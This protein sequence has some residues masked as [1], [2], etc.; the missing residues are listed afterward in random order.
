LIYYRFQVHKHGSALGRSVDLS[1]FNGYKELVE[2]LDRMFEFER[3]LV[4]CS[5]GWKVIYTD[6]EGDIKLIGDYPW[7]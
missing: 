5:K 4:D 1:K 7:P 3:D 2:E 6:D